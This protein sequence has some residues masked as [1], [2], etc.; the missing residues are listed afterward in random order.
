MATSNEFRRFLNNHPAKPIDEFEM[1]QTLNLVCKT[2]ESVAVDGNHVAVKLYNG[3]AV[4]VRE[5]GLVHFYIVIGNQHF[6]DY[7]WFNVSSVNFLGDRLRQLE[8]VP[9]SSIL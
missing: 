5:D 6:A 3:T 9:V 7:F 2:C 1:E 8:R 4:M